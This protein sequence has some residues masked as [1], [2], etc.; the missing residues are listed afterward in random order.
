MKFL[1]SVI[2]LVLSLMSFSASAEKNSEYELSYTMTE[3]S[4]VFFNAEELAVGVID[5]EVRID[6]FSERLFNKILKKSVIKAVKI[7]GV[8]AETKDD[9]E[10]EIEAQFNKLCTKSGRNCTVTF[11]D[12]EMLSFVPQ[13][14]I[15]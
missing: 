10:G 15:N 2:M 6:D 12:A 7:I 8:S 3:D 9:L 5:M 14:H 4:S 11:L 13:E 1:L